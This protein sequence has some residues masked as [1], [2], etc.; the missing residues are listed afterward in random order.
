MTYKY[1]MTRVPPAIISLSKTLTW[2]LRYKLVYFKL[3]LDDEGYCSWDDLFK[4]PCMSKFNYN[5]VKTLFEYPSAHE[6]YFKTKNDT[7]FMAKSGQARDVENR[8]KMRPFKADNVLVY[9][10][11]PRNYEFI[12]MQK[13]IRQMRKMYIYL[14]PHELND[15]YPDNTIFIYLDTKKMENVKL[16]TNKNNVVY[17]HGVNNEGY[18]PWDYIDCVVDRYTGSILYSSALNCSDQDAPL[19]WGDAPLAELA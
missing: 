5:D 19:C 17:T 3:P 6:R 4:L 15:D 9:R 18:I 11:N 14:T 7:L 12:K 8:C 13:Q 2:I 1:I 10:T 16:F